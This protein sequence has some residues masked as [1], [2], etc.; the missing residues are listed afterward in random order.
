LTKETKTE[1]K[2]VR[3]KPETMKKVEALAKTENRPI[4]YQLEQLIEEA[5]RGR[6]AEG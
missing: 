5:L 1:R 2:W 6:I 3:L 4:A